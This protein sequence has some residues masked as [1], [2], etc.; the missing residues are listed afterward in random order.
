MKPQ[1]RVSVVPWTLDLSDENVTDN[2]DNRIL[3]QDLW[4]VRLVGDERD[5]DAFLHGEAYVADRYHYV[6]DDEYFHCVDDV[7]DKKEANRIA[8]EWRERLK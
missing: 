6:P 3:S 2:D 7:P 1:I 5:I 4:C 8:K